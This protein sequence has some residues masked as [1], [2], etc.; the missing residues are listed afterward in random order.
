MAFDSEVHHE[1]PVF[2]DY[3]FQPLHFHSIDTVGG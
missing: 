2:K 1:S 3:D